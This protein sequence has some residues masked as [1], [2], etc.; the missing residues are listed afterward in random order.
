MSDFD[1]GDALEDAIENRQ[2]TVGFIFA[3]EAANQRA[4]QLKSLEDQL[5]VDKSRATTEKERLS[6]EMR[7]LEIEEERLALDRDAKSSGEALAKEI[8]VLRGIMLDIGDDLAGIRKG[9]STMLSGRLDQAITLRVAYV[10]V[11]LKL[12]GDRSH[13]LCDLGDLKE[14]RRLG[15]EFTGVSRECHQ[16]GLSPG[17]SLQLVVDEIKNLDKWGASA[18]TL[19]DRGRRMLSS[20][21]LRE[22][23]FRAG[24][25]RMAAVRAEL[26]DFIQTVD[27]DVE[28]ISR[29]LPLFCFKGQSLNSSVGVIWELLHENTPWPQWFIPLNRAI[30]GLGGTKQWVDKAR[31]QLAK[32]GPQ[33]VLARVD[34]DTLRVALQELERGN[35]QNARMLSARPVSE[36]FNDPQ[37]E[38]LA[39]RLQNMETEYAAAYAV[40]IKGWDPLEMG[41]TIRSLNESVLWANVD[42]QAEWGL[43]LTT[44]KLKARRYRLTTAIVPPLVVVAL[45]LVVMVYQSSQ[46]LSAAMKKVE[47]ELESDAKRGAGEVKVIEIAP[48]VTM[49]FC[50]CPAGKF[51]M[52]SPESEAGR[53]SDEDQVEVTL[54]EGFWMAKTEVTQAQWQAVL[55]ETPSK[56]IGA[57]RPVEN[58]SWD[59]AQEFLTKLNAIVGDSDRRKMV[60]PTE[61]QWEYAARAGETGPYSGGTVEEVAW[62]ADNSGSGTHEVATKRPNAWGLHDMHGNVREWCADWYEDELEGGVDPHGAAPGSNRGLRGGSWGRDAFG[63]RVA[64][65][66]GDV[67]SS[68][69]SGIGFRPARGL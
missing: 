10:Q 54:S 24:L 13:V 43:A 57:N 40:V 46:E 25:P 12:I 31:A 50:W 52:G 63:S 49:D 58:V 38:Q 37:W 14:F 22:G 20:D 9:A 7:R 36:R 41:R 6:V 1:F 30:Q 29:Q 33:E 69:G 11:L 18:K 21:L 53:S 66:L 68:R 27:S 65:R 15:S 51:T 5:A 34:N 67:P 60:L 28:R 32:I 48:G 19:L 3:Q 4:A 26:E 64:F 8:R 55:G 56:F 47:I 62:Y 17:D 61:A 59:D 23:S 39:V 16:K 42:P 45:L 2:N 35:P 44:L